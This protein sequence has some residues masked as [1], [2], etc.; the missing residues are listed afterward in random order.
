MNRKVNELVGSP[1][2]SIT[3]LTSNNK[4]ANFFHGNSNNS[5][6]RFSNPPSFRGHN[7]MATGL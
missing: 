4:T 1:T 5:S 6:V 3:S 7:G 2:H